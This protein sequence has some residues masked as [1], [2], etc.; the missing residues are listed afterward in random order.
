LLPFQSLQEAFA[1]AD[2]QINEFG[3]SAEFNFSEKIPAAI[4]VAIDKTQELKDLIGGISPAPIVEDITSNVSVE[5]L[6]AVPFG[7]VE[8]SVGKTSRA[9]GKQ[10]GNSNRNRSAI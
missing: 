4:D 5:G 8:E 2:E 1:K 9:R 7:P 6:G 3:Y 10:K